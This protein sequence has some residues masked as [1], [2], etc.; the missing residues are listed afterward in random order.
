MALLLIPMGQRRDFIYVSIESPI[1]LIDLVA[2]LAKYYNLST[3]KHKILEDFLQEFSVAAVTCLID[4][5]RHTLCYILLPS[6]SILTCCARSS[7][8]I[9]LNRIVVCNK[10]IE[11]MYIHKSVLQRHYCQTCE[12]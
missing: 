12:E 11:Y 5:N 2:L 1:C 9:P 8:Q 7:P 10:C 6:S 4:G 3:A